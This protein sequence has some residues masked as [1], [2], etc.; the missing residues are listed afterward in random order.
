M[1]RVRDDGVVSGPVADVEI[2][3]DVVHQLLSQ[4]CPQW[5]DLPLA[6]VREGWDNVLFRLGD[7]LAVRM[8]RRT[9]AAPLIVNEQRWLPV[10]A[11]RLPLP[12][13]VPLHQGVAGHGYPWSW[14]VVPW[15]EGDVIGDRPPADWDRVAV[16]LG[17]FLAALHLPAP[18]DAP[19]NP[20]RGRPLVERTDRLLVGLDTVGDAVDRS[21]VEAAWTTLV[22]T[23]TDHGP[24]RWLH[25]DLHPLN[26][27]VE[28]DA[29]S[30]VIDFGDLTAGDRAADLS[31]A[32]IVLPDHARA[33]FR[34]AAGTVV[35]IDD[36][37]WSRARA[38]SLALGVAYL[39]GDERTAAIGRHA[40]A[41]VLAHRA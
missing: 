6:R 29:L 14:S 26:I 2:D 40:V 9:M 27:L 4:Q 5:T 16:Q 13:P 10:L 18:R 21:A 15:I 35:P 11:P 33:A 32:W 24:P 28:R 20:Y 22:D 3:E 36:H 1:G 34:E 31:V 23:P 7:D 37:T 19:A 8:P 17:A 41:E 39:H 12:V 38:W 30:G 25:G